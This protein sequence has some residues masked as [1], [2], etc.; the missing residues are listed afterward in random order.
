MKKKPGCLGYIGDFYILYDPD[1][2]KWDN[3]QMNN[4]QNL[5]WLFDIGDE[6]LSSYMWIIL[7][8]EVRIPSLNNQDPMEK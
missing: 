2:V 6:K 3:I 7:N 1:V 4:E 5:G 8:H